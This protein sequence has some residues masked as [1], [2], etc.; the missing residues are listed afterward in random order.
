VR[1][2]LRPGNAAP[3]RRLGCRL[4]RAWWLIVSVGAAALMQRLASAS[5]SIGLSATKRRLRGAS[6]TYFTHMRLQLNDLTID[7]SFESRR[8]Q[9][10]A[11][12]GATRNDRFPAPN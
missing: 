2:N 5:W 6:G 12:H 4:S 7:L 8:P 10:V 11:G 9:G 3:V 1:G